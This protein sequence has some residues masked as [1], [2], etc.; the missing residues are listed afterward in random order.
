MKSKWLGV[1]G[2]FVI[3]L[4]YVLPVCWHTWT[5]PNKCEQGRMMGVTPDCGPGRVLFE[6]VRGDVCHWECRRPGY[7][8]SSTEPLDLGPCSITID[9]A[10]LKSSFLGEDDGG[11]TYVEKGISMYSIDCHDV[12]G[13]QPTGPLS[14]RDWSE[15]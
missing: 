5:A 13:F 9:P 2:F 4:I 6:E 11:C 10:D 1:V 15:R 7:I 3:I 14:C 8:Y 12:A